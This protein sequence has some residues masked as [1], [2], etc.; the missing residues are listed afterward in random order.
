M[1]LIDT[2]VWL[3]LLLEQEKA[4]EVRNLLEKHDSSALYITEFTLYSIGIILL[5]LKK[6]ELFLSFIND[7]LFEAGISV[8]RLSP[9]DLV[10]IVK[11]AERFNLDFDDAY[12]YLVAIQNDLTI[13]SFDSDFDRTEKGRKLP[14][15]ISIP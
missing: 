11:I 9:V 7:T 3:E 10:A 14:A 6:A 8:L 5:K 1:Y 2:N 13:V 12:Q 4:Q 15:E